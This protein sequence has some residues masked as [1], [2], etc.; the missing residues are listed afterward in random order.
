MSMERSRN[1]SSREETVSQVRHRV[2]LVN[3]PSNSLCTSVAASGA[4][5][6]LELV[7]VG[8]IFDASVAMELDK[9]STDEVPL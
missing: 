3:V 8:A 5:P 1:D 2:S 9:S 6:E 4:V 7:V